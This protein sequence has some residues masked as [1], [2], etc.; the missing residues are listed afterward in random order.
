M[1]EERA[2]P[3]ERL[4]ILR[5]VYYYREGMADF[6]KLSYCA[7]ATVG[8]R[9]GS[10]HR[11]A[12]ALGRSDDTV[13]ALANAARTLFWLC[14]AF[15]EAREYEM[16]ARTRDLRQVLSYSHF[17]CAGDLQRAYDIHPLE[18]F[19]ILDQAAEHHVG[20]QQMR[21]MVEAQHASDELKPYNPPNPLLD[22]KK[23][24][25][26]VHMQTSMHDGNTREEA[27]WGIFSDIRLPDSLGKYS[28]SLLM[29]P[30]QLPC[31]SVVEIVYRTDQVIPGRTL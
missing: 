17:D 22:V 6:W 14:K 20:V 16:Q 31:G 3:I 12:Q 25:M 28:L 30:E 29:L 11:M 10:T 8:R 9:D 27:A 1:I 7:V 15:R 18:L 2:D 24:K 4:A 26:V 19:S 21:Q 5:A 23:W 13:E